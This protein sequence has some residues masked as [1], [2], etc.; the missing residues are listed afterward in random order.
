MTTQIEIKNL[1]LANIGKYCDY[2]TKDGEEGSGIIKK[3]VNQVW[4]A[5][6]YKEEFAIDSEDI[7]SIE[8]IQE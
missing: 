3:G 2:K 1:L 5:Y 8:N 6:G 7:I 4:I